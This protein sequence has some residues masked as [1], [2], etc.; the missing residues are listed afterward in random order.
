MQENNVVVTDGKMCNSK[1]KIQYRERNSNNKRACFL[2]F[3]HYFNFQ[4]SLQ[5]NSFKKQ[6]TLVN[7]LISTHQQD[8]NNFFLSWVCMHSVQ[9][10]L[11]TTQMYYPL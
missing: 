1:Y 9:E 3:M 5:W 4:S 7:L 2:T 11:K 6:N 8:R 10:I